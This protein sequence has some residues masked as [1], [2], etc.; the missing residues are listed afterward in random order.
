MDG[1]GDIDL[2]TGEHRGPNKKVQVWENSGKVSFKLHLIDQGKEN[3]LGTL[4]AD[5]DNDGDMD[6]LGIAW[7]DFQYLHLWRNDAVSKT[8]EST[9]PKPDGYYIPVKVEAVDNGY[10]S[11]PIEIEI[12][13][14]ELIKKPFD[15]NS[16][17]VAEVDSAGSIIDESVSFQFD[18]AD[19]YDAST[20]ASGTLIFVMKGQTPAGSTR[21][22]RVY[23]N[24]G[25]FWPSDMVAKQVIV[26]D[27]FMD[28][29][30]NCFQIVT[31]NASYYF[32]KTGSG[33]TSITDLNRKDWIGY[34]RGGRSAG[35][36]R[37]IPNLRGAGFHPGRGE[38]KLESK[39]I[40]E[41]PLKVKI[42]SETE[43]RKWGSIWEI[44]PDYAK[45]TLFKKG[46]DPYYFLYEGV[47][48][49]KLDMDTDFWVKS[50]GTKGPASQS[51]QGDLAAPE[52]VY[53][54][55]GKSKRALYLVNHTDDTLDDTYRPMKENMTVF[56]FGRSVNVKGRS[57]GVIDDAP[58]S[59]TIGFVEDSDFSNAKT[60]ITSAYHQPDV[61]FGTAKKIK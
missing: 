43:D 11:K 2:V 9:Q 41:G 48:G 38:G 60:I 59:F 14:S 34:N 36:F 56:G 44:Y 1:D 40:S 5:M 23:F 49:G 37:G 53:F 29:K 54:V 8:A 57:I 58:R 47:P 27:N 26:I 39:I 16:I 19:N 31:S 35:E 50:D 24:K 25:D 7:D 33:F 10:I 15:E 61:S 3:H 21:N 17:K 45:M 18:K 22:Y 42:L 30:E 20:N 52:W 51:W 4:L 55:D 28:A 32:D 46:D 6:M 12:N 13:F